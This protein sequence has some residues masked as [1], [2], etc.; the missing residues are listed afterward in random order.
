MVVCFLYIDSV[1]DERQHV[2]QL[3]ECDFRE[4]DTYNIAYCI[5]FIQLTGLAPVST[6][7]GM[8]Q[9]WSAQEQSFATRSIWYKRV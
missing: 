3:V 8:F 1:P 9:T 7:A 4:I 2:T 6:Q 5:Y